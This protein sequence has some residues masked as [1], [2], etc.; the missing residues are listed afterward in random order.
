MHAVEPRPR[1][2]DEIVHERCGFGRVRHG[3]RVCGHA[4]GVQRRC[5]IH[6]RGDQTGAEHAPDTAERSY[7]EGPGGRGAGRVRVDTRLAAHQPVRDSR[8]SRATGG[9]Q[10]PA[11]PSRPSGKTIIMTNASYNPI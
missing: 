10:Q 7:P 8:R 2:Y 1:Y 11:D 3:G 5:H 9:G 6:E 4:A